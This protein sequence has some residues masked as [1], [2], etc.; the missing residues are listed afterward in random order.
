MCFSKLIER[1][2]KRRKGF[3]DNKKTKTEVAVG[4]DEDEDVKKEKNLQNFQ[5]ETSTPKTSTENILSQPDS[6]TKSFKKKNQNFVSSIVVP[7]YNKSYSTPQRLSLSWLYFVLFRTFSILILHLHMDE[8]AVELFYALNHLDYT[9]GSYH[10]ILRSFFV[11][12]LFE[13]IKRKKIEKEKADVCE[14]FVESEKNEISISRLYEHLNNIIRTLFLPKIYTSQLPLY[15]SKRFRS[16]DPPINLLYYLHI[17]HMNHPD[18]IIKRTNSKFIVRLFLRN[19]SCDPTLSQM[20]GNDY[21]IS[22]EYS[23]AV[24]HYFH[25]LLSGLD[26]DSQVIK[27][28][29]GFCISRDSDPYMLLMIGLCYL[30]QVMSKSTI[31]RHTFCLRAFL[32]LFK[33][34]EIILV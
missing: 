1:K 8:D 3:A 14:K 32:F 34:A 33:Y 22:R 18:G 28:G 12:I 19:S 13:R 11:D 21:Y 27:K 23:T 4:G 15:E 25:V 31:D 24:A 2:E 17:I 9:Y 5:L 7:L 10:R 20:V 26:K 16:V 30:N 29:E 6:T